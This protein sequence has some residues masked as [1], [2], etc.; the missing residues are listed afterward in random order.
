M[1]RYSKAL[2]ALALAAGALVASFAGNAQELQAE[3]AIEAPAEEAGIQF[4]FR[5]VPLETILDYLSRSAGF[6][7]S[8]DSSIEGTVDVI[9]HQ[10]LT[11]DQAVQLLNSVLFD[12]GYTAV[13]SGDNVL[14]IVPSDT[15]GFEPL[16]VIRGSEPESIPKTHERVTQ[17][18]PLKY[19]NATQV[20]R[21]LQPLIPAEAIVTANASSNSVI[22]TDTQINIRRIA[23]IMASLDTAA[24]NSSSVRIFRLE[25]ASALETATLINEVFKTQGVSGATEGTG[26]TADRIAD[27]ISRM[28]SGGG[29]PGGGP[30]MMQFGGGGGPGR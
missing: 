3:G 4:N 18:M 29:F 2:W 5:G 14:R 1:K 21:D 6:A 20:I 10:L 17:I 15:A 25:R 28:R 19:A 23:E 24:T 11:K 27:F 8:F 16:P 22:I 9:S 12:K 13:R 7:I 26:P 30:G